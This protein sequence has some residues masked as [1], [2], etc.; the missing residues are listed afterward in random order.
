MPIEPGIIPASPFQADVAPLR[1]IHRWA[2]VV[3]MVDADLTRCRQPNRCRTAQRRRIQR[4]YEEYKRLLESM[5]EPWDHL[6]R[7]TQE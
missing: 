7:L 5:Q 4:L 1:C 2:K 6:D 3:V